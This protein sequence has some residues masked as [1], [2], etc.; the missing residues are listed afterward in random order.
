MRFDDSRFLC[1]IYATLTLLCYKIQNCGVF[2]MKR[3]WKEI[4]RDGK[5]AAVGGDICD[6]EQQGDDRDEPGG[7]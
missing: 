2:E 6:D 3:E 4:P 7:A 5:R 1:I